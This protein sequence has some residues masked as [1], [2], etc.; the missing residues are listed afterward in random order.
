MDVA[1]WFFLLI[2]G[3]AVLSGITCALAS[4]LLKLELLRS[5]G[6]TF[7]I[8]ALGSIGLLVFG[9]FAYEAGLH[10]TQGSNGSSSIA[11]PTFVCLASFALA[12][13]VMLFTLALTACGSAPSPV[14][15]TAA[16]NEVPSAPTGGPSA[17]TT[18]PPFPTEPPTP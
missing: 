17:A 18:E 7:A 12:F 10:A 14:N 16:T 8:W 9:G 13:V 2:V 6:P 15:S 1:G 3:T 5:E 4:T 11:D